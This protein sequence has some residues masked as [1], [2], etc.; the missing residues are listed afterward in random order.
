MKDNVHLL[1]WQVEIEDEEVFSIDNDL[2][3]LEKPI[4]KSTF[5]YP[6]KVDFATTFICLSGRMEGYINLKPIISSALSMTVILPGQILQYK[7]MSDDFTGLFTAMSNEFI[8]KLNMQ[9]NI[10]FFTS[11]R[12]NPVIPLTED[13]LK[14]MITNYSLLKDTIKREDNP[15]R[16]E[17]VIHLIKAFFYGAGHQFQKMSEQENKSKHEV[18]ID[19]F[20]KLVEK[21]Y[22]KERGII[23][24]ADKLSI[25]PK[26][27]SSLVKENTGKFANEWIDSYVIL[28]AEALLKS[29]NMTIQQISDNLNFSTQSVFG[30]YFKRLTGKS[31]KEYKNK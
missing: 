28:E 6:F 1:N 30:K 16:I 4:I 19:K 29:T 23:F 13:D 2:I 24:Y 27:L 10:P 21:H 9:A 17:T 5:S 22:K 25:T 12:E 14:P 26:Y 8:S 31:P 11:I 20:L 18:L 7:Y 3:L 15:Y